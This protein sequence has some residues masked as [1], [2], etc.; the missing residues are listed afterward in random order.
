MGLF[1]DYC[2]FRYQVLF[3]SHFSD[4]LFIWTFKN[5]LEDTW[6]LSLFHITLSSDFYFSFLLQRWARLW[7]RGRDWDQVGLSLGLK[8]FCSILILFL[9]SL[10]SFCF[11]SYCFL[12]LYYFLIHSN[13]FII[14]F[15]LCLFSFW[16]HSYSLS[17]WSYSSLSWHSVLIPFCFCSHSVIVAAW[18]SL[19]SIKTP[20]G[21]WFLH[22]K[23]KKLFILISPVVLEFFKGAIDNFK[24]VPG[25]FGLVKI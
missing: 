14:P 2:I 20:R 21:L 13:S 8:L 15:L 9:R 25:C 24:E 3:V 7:S 6:S 22:Q 10:F 11:R 16:F 12:I 4:V 18:R 19:Q 23:S 17:F 5:I 1:V